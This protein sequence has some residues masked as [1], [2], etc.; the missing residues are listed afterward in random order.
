MRDLHSHILPGIDDG[1]KDLE[2]SKK[3]IDELI[4]MSVDSVVLT[5]HYVE[6][7]KYESNTQN[8]KTLFN[9][10]KAYAN[11]K[12]LNVYLGNEV[13]INNNIIDLLKK[14]EITTINNSRYL[15]VELPL[16]TKLLDTRSI[17]ISL[18]NLGITPIIAHPERYIKY[19]R[20]LDFFIDLR[21]RGILFQINYP[22]LVGFYGHSA[23]KIAK[24][25]L[26][27]NLVSFIGSDI[28]HLDE[29]NFHDADKALKKINK[30][31][32]EDEANRIINTN[33]M[34]VINNEE[35]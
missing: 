8:N 3:I 20:D 27:N 32:G 21:T 30:L 5:P 15:L 19:Y 24:K 16:T 2:E 9:E 29:G 22:S 34:K 26:K 6:G 31:V 18:K 17:L 12:G 25:L 28:H 10:V 7:S 14:K 13:Y 11:K 33:F 4:K 23:K 35:I 1:S